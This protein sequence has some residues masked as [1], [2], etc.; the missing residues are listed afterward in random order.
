MG[1]ARRIG[2]KALPLGSPR[3]ARVAALARATGLWSGPAD[4]D[5]QRWVLAPSASRMPIPEPEP[6]S[7]PI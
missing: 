6:S 4:T 7:I 2:G 5:Y 1:L 3:R